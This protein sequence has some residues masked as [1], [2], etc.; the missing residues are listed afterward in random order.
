MKK[1]ISI[2]L[3]TMFLIVSSQVIAESNSISSVTNISRLSGLNRYSTAGAIGNEYFANGADTVILA[4][5]DH[6]NGSPQITSALVSASLTG[7]LDVPILLTTQNRVPNATVDAL[8]NLSPQNILII[9]NESEV[10]TGI[11]RDLS[12]DYNITRVQGRNLS[13][14]AK[15]IALYTGDS[16]NTAYIVQT[17]A[18]PDALA[19]GSVASATGN[20]IL[21]TNKNSIPSATLEAISTLGIRDIYIIGGTAVISESVEQQLGNAINGNVNRV[22]GLNRYETSVEIGKTF[23]N[24]ADKV[25][26]ANGVSMVDAVA[27]SILQRPLMLV[28]HNRIV[29]SA[30]E[31]IKKYSE[32]TIIGGETVVEKGLVEKAI[33]PKTELISDVTPAHYFTFDSST[34]T[35]TG[36]SS[37]GPKEVI[38][39]SKIE[40]VTVSKIG[41]TAFSFSSLTELTIPDSVTEIGLMAFNYNSL[42]EVTIPDSVTF[43]GKSAFHGNY[44]NSVTIGSGIRV[45]GES[46]FNRN[47][48][49]ELVIPDNVT[50]IGPYAFQNNKLTE[51]NLSSNTTRI[52][53]NA[54]Y[55]NSLTT[56]TIPDSVTLIGG[57]AFDQNEL[58][59]VKLGADVEIPF[60]TG[61]MGVNHGLENFYH[62]KGKQKG[63]YYWDGFGW[64]L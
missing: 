7:V 6:Q 55:G 37:D 43:I 5:G 15:E 51:I 13:E 18:L 24:N 19:I 54:F 17:E 63:T 28:Q 2:L 42:T 21:L 41:F 4:R 25:T 8:D 29:G 32:H 34:G 59:E 44:L 22:A 61:T 12:K 3:V 56:V 35:I 30:Q 62:F 27:S 9:G 16:K 14:T 53:R 1:F 45:I 33:K 57:H 39:P 46:A 64:E 36:Y 60:I 38:I 47:K 20:P 10:S 26:I 49:T 52:G 23:W 48:L 40:G 50:A 11:E 58:T 31:E